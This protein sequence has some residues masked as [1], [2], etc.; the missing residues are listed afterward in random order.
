M[1]QHQFNEPG[2]PLQEPRE[3]DPG[4][5]FDSFARVSRDMVTRPREFFRMLPRGAELRPPVLFLSVCAFLSALFMANTMKSDFRFFI[6]LFVS[7]IASAFVG[8]LVLHWLLHR[9]Y[10]STAAFSDT[11][12]I[13]AYTNLLDIVAWIPVVGPVGSLYGLYL[14]FIGLQEVHGLPP[15]QASGVL[16]VI[17]GVVLAMLV[18]VATGTQSLTQTEPGLFPG[19]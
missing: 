18:L 12:R 10:R 14:I 19:N 13:I 3:F 8:S 15:R 9:F 7:Q 1:N 11:F 16:I 6:T 5:F 4:R 2:A 17:V